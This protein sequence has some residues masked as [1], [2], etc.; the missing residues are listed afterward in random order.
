MADA[1]TSQTIRDGDRNVVMKFTNLSD[2]SG[3][4]DVLK[5]DVSALNGSPSTVRI[6]HVQY[7]IAGMAVRIRWDADTD[8]DALVLQGSGFLDFRPYGGIDNNAGTG[9]TGDIK[10][11]T[12]GHTAGDSYT[13]V[14]GME[15]S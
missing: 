12:N 13:I 2:G 4:S 11:T 3:E 1:V 9:V 5:V 8:V 10:F 6:S 15:K 14:L 7:D